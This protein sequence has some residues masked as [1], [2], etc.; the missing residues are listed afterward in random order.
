MDF[1][2]GCRVGDDFDIVFSLSASAAVVFF[3]EVYYVHFLRTQTKMYIEL[4]GNE[5]VFPHFTFH[6]KSP[7]YL[8][9]TS[10]IS[11]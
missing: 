11:M 6:T 7:L 8:H 5:S 2:C 4:F 1:N 3:F 10:E 9:D